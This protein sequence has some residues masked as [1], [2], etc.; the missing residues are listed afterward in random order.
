VNIDS[1]REALPDSLISSVDAVWLVAPESH[2]CLERLTARIERI[3]IRILG[4]SAVAIEHASDKA[5]LPRRLSQ[6]GISHP[7]TLVVPPGSNYG[8]AARKIGYPVV[9]KPRRGAGCCGVSVATDS[10]QLRKA[11][12]AARSAYGGERLVMQRYVNGTAASAALVSDGCRAVPLALNAQLVS[13]S[14]TFSY[15]GGRTPFD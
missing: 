2:R 6:R 10:R 9:V 11:I 12:E 4:S 7:T 15:R 5:G 13:R 8:E 1:S 14:Q 3:G